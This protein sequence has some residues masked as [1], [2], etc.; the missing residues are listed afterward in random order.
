MSIQVR[1]LTIDLPIQDLN[2]NSLRRKLFNYTVGGRF[3]KNKKDEVIIRALEDVSFEVENGE[4]VGIVGHNGAGKT[5]LLRAVAGVFEPN[6][7]SVIIDGKITALF[8][9][10]IGLDIEATGLENITL[11]GAYLGVE[12]KP[13][14]P[15]VEEIIN[16][17]ELNNYIE[18]PVKTYSTGMLGRLAFA[19]A[20][21]LKPD[22]L[23]LDEWLG[24]G[25][26]FFLKKAQIRVNK[27]VD[28]AKVVLIASHSD[29]L[30]ESM[31]SRVVWLE[32]GKVRF[33]GETAKWKEMYQ[34]ELLKAQ[35]EPAI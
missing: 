4:R 19:V 34:E 15:V 8:G 3:L 2:A 27:F 32:R 33:F 21:S 26:Q 30:I 25:D 9:A 6:K 13:T 18:L 7:G 35:I 28:E 24:A 31:A 17:C 14:D 23:V 22:V 11:M 10:G 1:N 12:I 29:A 16:F 5:T 20:T